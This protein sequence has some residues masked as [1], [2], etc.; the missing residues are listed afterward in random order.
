MS[1]W[2]DVERQYYM[3]CFKRLPVVLV[4]G[5]GARVWDEDGKVYLDMVAGIAVNILGHAHPALVRAISE[6]AARLIHTSNLY[7]TIPQ[8]ELAK[9]LV[10]HSCADQVF[11]ANS[12]A[13]ANE[14]AIKLARKW[15]KLHR[16]GAYEII[17]AHNA[18]HGRTLA[19]VAAT[20]Q[21]KFSAPFTP[22]P[23]GFVH[24]PLND[25]AALQAATT[26]RTCAVMLEVIQGE[27]GVLMANWGYLREVRGWCDR[28][29]LLL[30]LDEIQTGMGRT[31]RFLAY[32][33]IGIEPDVFTMAKGLAGG[34]PVGALLAKESA[35][36]FEPSD[37]GS[38]FG[39]NPLACAAAL[40]TV[41]T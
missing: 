15:G 8:L 25:L 16:G 24:V 41:R 36:C 22:M 12:G 32:E 23:P 26:D 31:G 17:C 29:G 28:Q 18:F 19:T 13:E 30:I 14:G 7:Y 1:R 10:E 35:A 2:F 3:H 21:E 40:A 38:T 6:Q 27:S 37:H 39:G 5:E 11:Y 9:E 20:G 34:V 33:H 4:R